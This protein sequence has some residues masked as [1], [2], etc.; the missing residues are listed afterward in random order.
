MEKKELLV[1]EVD[2][3]GGR[4]TALADGLP[5][6]TSAITLAYTLAALACQ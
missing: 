6:A 2:G 3:L 5:L 4:L 1:Q